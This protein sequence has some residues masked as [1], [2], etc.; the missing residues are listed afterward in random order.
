MP[1]LTIDTLKPFLKPDANIEEL[2][3]LIPG[4]HPLDLLKDAEKD[5]AAAVALLEAHPV[6]K[7]TRDQLIQKAIDSYKEKHYQNDLNAAIE[8]ERKK[9]KVPEETPEQK[10]L[11]EAKE[12]IAALE[13]KDKDK[14]AIIARQGLNKDLAGKMDAAGVKSGPFAPVLEALV[15]ADQANAEALAKVLLEA[16]SGIVQE[17]KEKILKDNKLSFLPG[18]NDPVTAD[19]IQRQIEAAQKAGNYSE[20]LRLTELKQKGN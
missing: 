11:R 13:N 18:G 14:D 3:K 6:L 12:R 16:V 19:D 8:I 9:L 5:R 2:T 15:V 20:A 1:D 7:S 17:T 10:E 4:P